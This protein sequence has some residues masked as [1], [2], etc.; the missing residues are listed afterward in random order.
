[1]GAPLWANTLWL[2]VAA[3]TERATG[4]S[5]VKARR[6]RDEIAAIFFMVVDPSRIAVII[7]A[8]FVPAIVTI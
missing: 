8:A 7:N 6:A 2:T 4:S 5:M 3:L 1:M